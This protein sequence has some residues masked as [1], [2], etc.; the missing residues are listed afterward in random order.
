[1]SDDGRIEAEYSQLKAKRSGAAADAAEA[2]AFTI[3]TA[4][5]LQLAYGDNPEGAKIQ[6]LQTF[7]GL[8]EEGISNLVGKLVMSLFPIQAPWFGYQPNGMVP[9]DMIQPLRNYLLARELDIASKMNTTDYRAK[10]RHILEQLLIVGN[11]MV[12]LRDDYDLTVYRLNQYV[13]H[14]DGAG[15][16]RKLVIKELPNL[17]AVTEEQLDIANLTMDALVD[18]FDKEACWLYTKVQ[19]DPDPKKKHWRITQ[20]LNAKIIGER[21]EKI[22]PYIP[23][24]YDLLPNEHYARSFAGKKI[25]DLRSFNGLNKAILDGV[26]AMARGLVTVDPSSALTPDDIQNSANWAVVVDD[27]RDGKAVNLGVMTMDKS[28]DFGVAIQQEQQIENRLGRA[29]L[30]H[31][32]AQ[33]NAE[34][35]TAYEVMQVARELDGALGGLYAEIASNIQK[36]FLER[37]THQMERDALILPIP[38]QMKPFI[39]LDIRTGIE[40][41]SRQ[42]ELEKLMRS[43]QIVLQSEQMMAS[44]DTD[45]ALQR[46]F[47]LNMVDTRGGLIKSAERRQADAEAMM[48]QQMAAQAGGQAIQSMGKI[49]ENQASKES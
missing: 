40:A 28:R 8:G 41:L 48:K 46:I 22:S 19:W 4:F 45:V 7:Q 36:P 18:S 43:L 9:E 13:Q 30:L 33:R 42:I 32:A 11:V 29:M 17:D 24:L 14:C 39:E 47:E 26:V 21:T 12:F 37:F 35:V 27:T 5:P 20:E 23:L 25:G 1:M 38:Q 34:R 2:S 31:Q 6:L 44:L 16:V 49:A 10:M 15:K 3:P